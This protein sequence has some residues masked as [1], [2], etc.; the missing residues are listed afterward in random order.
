MKRMISGRVFE[1]D[2]KSDEKKGLSRDHGTMRS[3]PREVL[4][5]QRPTGENFL[6]TRWSSRDVSPG[7][8]LLRA[9]LIVRG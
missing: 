5:E 2:G 6:V 4:I 8:H 3:L 9:P 1:V 7:S